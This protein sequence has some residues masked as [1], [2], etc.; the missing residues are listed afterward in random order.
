[1]ISGGSDT[2]TGHGSSWLGGLTEGSV[3]IFVSWIQRPPAMQQQ[4]CR[5]KLQATRFV[6]M[7]LQGL[8]VSPGPRA[9]PKGMGPM[10]GQ[11]HDSIGA[12][13]GPSTASSG[14]LAVSS[15]NCC[16]HQSGPARKLHSKLQPLTER[17]RRASGIAAGRRGWQWHR[18]TPAAPLEV[19][20]CRRPRQLQ[21]V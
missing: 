19:S 1:M 3:P 11:N 7:T 5:C 21:H 14:E 6:W 8:P 9:G 18:L 17:T 4:P 15:R 10:S 20:A 16:H 13:S 2:C 12:Q